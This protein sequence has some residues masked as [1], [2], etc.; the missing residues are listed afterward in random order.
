[1]QK[2]RIG[3]DA[4]LILHEKIGVGV[5]TT[6]LYKALLDLNISDFEF[7]LYDDTY[8]AGF[9]YQG[10]QNFKNRGLRKVSYVIWLNT[11]FPVI[12]KRDKI[13]VVHA[14]NFIP[15][16]IK[17]CPTIINVHDIGFW[18]Y[19]EFY[20]KRYQAIL[21]RI[22]PIA[23]RS[24]DKIIVPSNFIRDELVKFVKV[25]PG[26]I[27]IIY[28][29]PGQEF[30]LINEIRD[31]HIMREKLH[32]PSHYI[33]SIGLINRR[34]NFQTLIKAF[35]IIS[36]KKK[37][38]EYKL[39]IIGK[40]DG[41]LQN[42]VKMAIQFNLVNDV[43]FYNYIDS[44]ILP[45]FYAFADVFV[46][47]SLYEGFGLPLL[48][49]MQFGIPIIASQTS[50]IPEILGDAG[51]MV[52]P[53]HAENMAEAIA[54]VLEHRSLQNELRERGYKR[55]LAFSWREAAKQTVAIYQS[56]IR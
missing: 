29:G 56:V 1:M 26:K 2:T 38:K 7:V 48:E 41:E 35:S 34:K 19:P 17:V 55:V 15:P 16:F 45:Y 50:S 6:G 51:I 20:D 27:A 24:A 4:R 21:K 39:V 8:N 44:V 31:K 47:P 5:Y 13:K 14:P 40:D 3:I 36:Q 23:C 49:A 22:L 52:D 53:L 18:H 25:P 33:F 42:L 12:L 54:A 11:V 30:K 43:I 10:F 46:Y 37:L 9:L 28:C 32:L